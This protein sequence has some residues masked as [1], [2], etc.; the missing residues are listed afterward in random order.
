[1]LRVGF[2]DGLSCLPLRMGL[3][4]TGG[5][6]GV[7]LV[8][9][10]PDETDAMLL[11]GELELGLVSSASWEGNRDRLWRV[12]G[13]GIASDGPVMD[14][15]LAVRRG[16]SLREAR[17]VALASEAATSHGLARVV[18]ERVCGASPRYE[19]V[20]PRPGWALAEYDAALFVGEAALEAR[21]LGGVDTVDLGE[22][23]REYASLPMVYAVWA[24][25]G[26]PA[27]YGFWADRVALAVG[28]AELHADEVVEEARRRGAPATPED[29]REYFSAIGY[30]VGLREGEGLKRYLA[31]SRL[32]SAGP[33]GRVSA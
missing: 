32:L 7:E 33:F 31:E 4:A 20:S 27:R 22:V 30:R 18:L 16:R 25:R 29:L 10:A 9:G 13:Y 1:M 2:V 24:S 3:Q 28:W 17:S 23:W 6:D 21:R 26:D 8:G 19:V 14:A 12:P 5:L 15:L 11:S